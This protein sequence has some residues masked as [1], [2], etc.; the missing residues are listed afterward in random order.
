MFVGHFKCIN[1]ICII[2]KLSLFRNNISRDNNSGVFDNVSS[3]LNRN[4]TINNNNNMTESIKDKVKRRLFWVMWKQHVDEFDSYKDY[5]QSVNRV[6]S[7]RGEIKKDLEKEYPNLF[8]RT[9]KIVWF[10]KHINRKR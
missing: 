5:K 9:R 6:V 7:A 2:S 8:R 4:D 3:S 10:V 1:D